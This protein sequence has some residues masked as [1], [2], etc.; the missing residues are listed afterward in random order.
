MDEL[1]EIN[2]MVVRLSLAAAGVTDNGEFRGNLVK[3]AFYLGR[4][5]EKLLAAFTASEQDSQSG[6]E[7]E[8][9]EQP[10][11]VDEPARAF[12]VCPKCKGIITETAQTPKGEWSWCCV[13]NQVVE[14]GKEMTWLEPR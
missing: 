10:E 7:G 3:I 11:L 2:N 8:I 13:C 14:P 5:Y 12:I 6:G 4:E 9:R 1:W